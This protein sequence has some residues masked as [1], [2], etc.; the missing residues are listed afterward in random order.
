MIVSMKDIYFSTDIEADGPIPGPYS[1]SSIGMVIAGWRNEDGTYVNADMDANENQFYAELKPISHLFIP[2]AAA[3]AGLNRE[4]LEAEG[5]FPESIMKVL[6]AWVQNRCKAL[7]GRPVFLAYPLSYDWMWFYWYSMKFA[8]ESAFGHSGALDI[9]TAYAVTADVALGKA[10][11]RYIPRSLMSSRKHT[12]NA[13]DD[14]KEQGELG[15]N[16]LRLSQES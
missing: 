11:K 12:H 6:N 2:E 8:G 5:Q 3:V 7:G 10:T 16:V 15:M 13:L 1:M 14:A 4:T 9:K